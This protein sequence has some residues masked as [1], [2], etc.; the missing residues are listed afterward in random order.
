MFGQTFHPGWSYPQS[1][2]F[3]LVTGLLFFASVVAHEL[4][5]S[6]VARRYGI[7]VKS[8]TLFIFGGIA[9]IEREPE[10]PIQEFN[11]AITGPAVSAL[12]GALFLSIGSAAAGVLPGVATQGQWLGQ[13]NLI[14][15][16]FN[17]VPGFPLDGG[18]V[19][20]AIAWKWTGSF[21]RGTAIATTTGSLFAYMLISLGVIHAYRTDLFSGLWIAF[22][23]WFLLNAAQTISIQTRLKDVLHAIK[24]S[25]VMTTD[26]MP[27]AP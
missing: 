12:I 17:L 1:I 6:I 16:F 3:G 27:P 9:Q 8:I 10:K 14:L 2:V 5:H 15:A 21:N 22:I 19:L 23:G 4:G 18:R 25:D 26:C 7:P 13:T 24:A 11:I 20:R